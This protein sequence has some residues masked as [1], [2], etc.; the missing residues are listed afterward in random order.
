MLVCSGRVG[1]LWCVV[2]GLVCISVL[3]CEVV[4][5]SQ[6]VV[7]GRFVVQNITVLI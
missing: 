4:S 2:E 6:C 3:C 5:I 7:S 1:M